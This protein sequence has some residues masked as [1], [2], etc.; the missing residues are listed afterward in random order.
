MIIIILDLEKYY[1]DYNIASGKFWKVLETS[2]NF[3][4]VLESSRSFWKHLEGD[5]RESTI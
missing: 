2:G 4:K 3:L 5:L 1:Y